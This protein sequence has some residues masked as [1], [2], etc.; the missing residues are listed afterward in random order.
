MSKLVSKVGESIVGGGVII[1]P[2]VPTVLINGAPVGVVGALVS[3][4]PPCPKDPSHCAPTVQTG[5]ATVLAGGIS[6]S[7]VSDIASCG[8]PISTGSP[9][10][11]VGG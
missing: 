11:L 3:S 5:S 10:T 2:L 9:N 1:V 4:H 8:H 7:G 6:I